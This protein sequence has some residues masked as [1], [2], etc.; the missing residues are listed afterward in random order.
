MDNGG[1]GFQSTRPMTESLPR[2]QEVGAKCLSD[3]KAELTGIILLPRVTPSQR[4]PPPTATTTGT[5]ISG[6][7]GYQCYCATEGLRCQMA[8]PRRQPHPYLSKCHHAGWCGSGWC[9]GGR[10]W[11]VGGLAVGG[12]LNPS[13]QRSRFAPFQLQLQIFSSS[14]RGSGPSKYGDYSTVPGGATLSA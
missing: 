1:K 8:H 9:G 12:A 14:T 6:S 10:G 11:G 7:G 5:R 4:A 3:Q 13:P 2:S